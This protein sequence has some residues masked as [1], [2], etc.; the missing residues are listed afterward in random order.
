MA[1]APEGRAE[2][3]VTPYILLGSR[4]QYICADIAHWPQ[5]IGFERS[6]RGGKYLPSGSPG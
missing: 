3:A 5:D 2:V 6:I 4:R 1:Q